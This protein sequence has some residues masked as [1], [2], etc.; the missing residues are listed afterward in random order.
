[1][2]NQIPVPLSA[3]LARKET[4][5]LLKQRKG[6]QTELVWRFASSVWLAG[7]QLAVFDLCFLFSKVLHVH[8]L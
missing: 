1:M 8:Y 3:D 5:H 7:S 2:S 6:R 4:A